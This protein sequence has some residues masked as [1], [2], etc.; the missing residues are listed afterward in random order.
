MKNIL[1]VLAKSEFTIQFVLLKLHFDIV[2]EFNKGN[3]QYNL[4]Y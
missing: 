1:V 2:F 3:L 4:C